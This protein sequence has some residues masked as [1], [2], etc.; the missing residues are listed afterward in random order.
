[1]ESVAVGPVKLV[2]GLS[3]TERL[4]LLR[5]IIPHTRRIESAHAQNLIIFFMRKRE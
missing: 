2:F 3:A 1:M 4:F 5:A